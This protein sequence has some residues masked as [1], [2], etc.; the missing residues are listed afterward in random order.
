MERPFG[1]Q[2]SVLEPQIYEKLANQ[3]C[4]SPFFFAFFFYPRSNSSTSL[5]NLRTFIRNP[6][7]FS[8]FLPRFPPHRSTPTGERSPL[9][10][11]SFF[12]FRLAYA[13][14]TRTP[15]FSTFAFTPSPTLDNSLMHKLLR[16]KASPYFPSPVKA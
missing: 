9:L 1:R 6:S 16:V 2:D 13:R 8:S 14:I 12:A 15:L 4:T 3:R 11:P 7:A 5:E 10:Q